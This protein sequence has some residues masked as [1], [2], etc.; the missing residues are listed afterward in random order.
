MLLPPDCRCQVRPHYRIAREQLIG[1]RAIAFY[2][3]CTKIKGMRCS[4]CAIFMLLFV[5]IS[6][7]READPPRTAEKA[8]TSPT[9]RTHS[10]VGITP[11]IPAPPAPGDEDTVIVPPTQPFS[12]PEGRAEAPIVLAKHLPRGLAL[13]YLEP[14]RGLA[15]VLD[16]HQAHLFDIKADASVDARAPV[17][18]DTAGRFTWSE[19]CGLLAAAGPTAAFD[20]FLL[21]QPTGATA[22]ELRRL[23]ITAEGVQH[24]SLPMPG[25]VTRH[26][27]DQSCLA[28][29]SN[30][31]SDSV[32]VALIS[33]EAG[34]G[35]VVDFSLSAGQPARD[36]H[37]EGTIGMTVAWSRAGALVG[38]RV[39][40]GYR[41]WR[42]DGE[43]ATIVGTLSGSH[44]GSLSERDGTLGVYHMQREPPRGSQPYGTETLLWTPVSSEQLESPQTMGVLAARSWVSPVQVLDGGLLLLTPP[45][46][47]TLVTRAAA[48]VDATAPD[49][50][51]AYRE[52]IR[53][54]RAV[55]WR[56]RW[57]LLVSLT[58]HR[59]R[60]G[61]SGELPMEASLELEWLE[62][63]SRSG[64]RTP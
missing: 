37:L 52:E 46:P 14:G 19:V 23:H 12:P 61:R 55:R 62:I 42:L 64:A 13:A 54:A 60:A 15:L 31:N 8:T 18:L 10:S 25:I 53:E 56:E 32:R 27:S 26:A 38:A 43:T 1:S 11:P 45:R 44:V 30:D 24:T 41:V 51:L 49:A 28:W 21:I 33:A 5:L 22:A 39:S 20:A 58:G 4:P 63:T 7:C 35:R 59:A 16:G 34:Q 9:K 36:V 57:V 6:G 48:L 2:R 17:A 47:D 3:R 50:L 40:S 29:R